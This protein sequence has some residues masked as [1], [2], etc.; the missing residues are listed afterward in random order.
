MACYIIISK[1]KCTILIP[2]WLSVKYL[3]EK[4]AEERTSSQFQEIEFY[5]TEIALMLFEW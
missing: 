4:V 2:D 3:Q 5:Y 1:E